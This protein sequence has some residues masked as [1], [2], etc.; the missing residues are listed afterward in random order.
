M[1]HYKIP[2]RWDSEKILFEGEFETLSDCTE[3]AVKQSVNL[4]RSNLSRSDLSDS[5]L[6][7]SNLSDSN[8]SNSNLRRSNLWDCTGNMSEIKSGQLET[9]QF[10]YTADRLQIGCKNHS[11]D[12][13]KNFSDR[14][15]L[16]MDGKKALTFWKKWKDIIF[17]IIEMSPAT[18]T[19]HESK[20]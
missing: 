12:E 7:R 18:P 19:G 11:I 9:Y 2:S 20:D 16:E 14:E 15:I 13:W 17:Q 10:A 4:R 6:R 5:D 3:T 8:L 1:Q